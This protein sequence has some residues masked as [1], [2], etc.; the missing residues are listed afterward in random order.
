MTQLDSI[1][2]NKGFSEW[3]QT[4]EVHDLIGQATAETNSTWCF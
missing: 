1:L 3:I 4:K 2:K